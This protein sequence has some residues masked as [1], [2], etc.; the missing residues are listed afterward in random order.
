[1]EKEGTN[2]G[3]AGQE[4]KDHPPGQ[5]GTGNGLAAALKPGG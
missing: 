2:D 4:R 5:L 1:M 3:E